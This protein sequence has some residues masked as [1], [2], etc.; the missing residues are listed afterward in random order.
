[1]LG[2]VGHLVCLHWADCTEK[3]R[4][5]N[6]KYI[7]A[8]FICFLWNSNV[9][10][11]SLMF[12][13]GWFLALSQLQLCHAQTGQSIEPTSW[14]CLYRNGQIKE[15]QH[16]TA[17]FDSWNYFSRA[18]TLSV[19]SLTRDWLTQFGEQ[20]KCRA[21]SCGILG[22]ETHSILYRSHF[23]ILRSLVLHSRNDSQGWVP[24]PG[25]TYWLGQ[26]LG[27]RFQELSNHL[28]FIKGL[29][30]SSVIRTLESLCL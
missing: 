20:V 14:L 27:L 7:Q 8:R 18:Q 30:L 5:L 2:F 10:V 16:V 24:E 17:V 19:V 4:T 11:F 26:K 28:D 25:A 23:S 9:A 22:S 13:H 29:L 3:Y 21:F 12:C 1:M 6:L 15:K